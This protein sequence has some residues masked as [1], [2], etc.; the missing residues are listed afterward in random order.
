MDF[1]MAAP[2]SG[3]ARKTSDGNDNAEEAL[4]YKPA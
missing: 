4:S 3:R 2:Y 1:S